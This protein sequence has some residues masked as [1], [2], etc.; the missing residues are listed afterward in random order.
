MLN[1]NELRELTQK[2]KLLQAQETVIKLSMQ[3]IKEQL[4]ANY[5]NQLYE[6]PTVKNEFLTLT[7]V[8][9]K[10]TQIFDWKK[11]CQKN[12]SDIEL[13]DIQEKNPDCIEKKQV[14]G[15]YRLLINSKGVE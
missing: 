4:I 2:Y 13:I 10:E 7:Y 6:K 9:P 5:S 12:N 11:Y 3:E 1:Q 14:A 8:A 15:S